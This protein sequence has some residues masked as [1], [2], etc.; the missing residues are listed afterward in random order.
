L[1]TG[2]SAT[3]TQIAAENAISPESR[4]RSS[5]KKWSYRIEGH[6]IEAEGPI[7]PEWFV[8]GDAPEQDA[9]KTKTALPTR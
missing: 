4:T 9:L 3:S 7:K 8:F 1:K 6:L 2:W 5:G